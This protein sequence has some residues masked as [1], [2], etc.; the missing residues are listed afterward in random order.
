MLHKANLVSAI[1]LALILSFAGCSGGKPKTPDLAG[2]WKIA[3]RPATKPTDS[4]TGN[5]VDD[6]HASLVLTLKPDGKFQSTQVSFVLTMTMEGTWSVNDHNLTL[7][8][9]KVGGEVK[10]PEGTSP[11]GKEMH[12][13]VSD[14]G[15]QLIFRRGAGDDRFVY[16]KSG[17]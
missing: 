17:S 8:V 11:V 1:A 15:K 14:D 12:F 9:E 3:S 6:T 2:T 4:V 16:E 13:T 5:I 7:A 10:L